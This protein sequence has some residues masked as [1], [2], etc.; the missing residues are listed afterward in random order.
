MTSGENSQA[1]KG[2]GARSGVA[3]AA[4]GSAALGRALEQAGSGQD[5]VGDGAIHWHII[6]KAT[7]NN[8]EDSGTQSDARDA[9]SID[10]TAET[11]QSQESRSKEMKSSVGEMKS[12]QKAK[13][14]SN[15]P[16]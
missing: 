10:E 4:C 6:E 11:K 9:I 12:T 1:E 3:A 15:A 8:S 2:T 14:G 7:K 5:G 16:K 13:Y